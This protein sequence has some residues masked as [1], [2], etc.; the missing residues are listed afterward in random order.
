MC[1]ATS[2][3]KYEKAFL[4]ALWSM[5][6]TEWV[7]STPPFDVLCS[8]TVKSRISENDTDSSDH[9]SLQEVDAWRLLRLRM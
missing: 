6:V 7:P 9:A 4:T 2:E 3:L 1:L 8:R 5:M